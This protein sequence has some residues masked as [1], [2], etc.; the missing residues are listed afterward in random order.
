MRIK[1]AIILTIV[2]FPITV[3][4]SAQP[5]IARGEPRQKREASLA[6]GGEAK[7]PT[8]LPTPA[9]PPATARHKRVGSNGGQVICHADYLEYHRAEGVVIAKGQARIT[10]GNI[11]LE[12]DFCKIDM[13]TED[14]LAEGNC[15]L[16][17]G[18]EEIKGDTLFYNLREDKGKLTNASSFSEP[19]YCKGKEI[20]KVGENLYLT[21]RGSFTTCDLPEPHYKFFAHSARICP[22]KRIWLYN[23]LFCVGKLPIFYL[24]FYTRSLTDKPYGLVIEPSHS[25]K[26]GWKV[27][28]HYSYYFNPGSRG[29]IYLDY[30]ERRGWG[31]GMDYRYAIGDRAQGTL[32][33]YYINE[34]EIDYDPVRDKYFNTG[35]RTERWKVE[36]RHRQELGPDTVG[37]L[38][39]NRLSDQD[40]NKDYNPHEPERVEDR[41]ES[42]LSI[43]RSRPNYTLRFLTKR[44]DKWVEDKDEYIKDTEEIPKLTFTTSPLRVAKAP[45]YYKVGSNLG[46]L[47]NSD[48]DYHAGTWNLYQSL[49]RRFRL[50]PGIN[51]N[52]KVGCKGTWFDKHSN[53]DKSDVWVGAY[54]TEVRLSRRITRC[55][56]GD[57]THS[58]WDNL[59]DTEVTPFARTQER[60]E[61]LGDLRWRIPKKLR[62]KLGCGYDFEDDVFKK[63]IT[64]M[65]AWPRKDV[66]LY[67]E[68]G[69]DIESGKFKN[70]NSNFFFHREM[71]SFGIGNRYTRGDEPIND[72]FDLNANLSFWLT[73][74]WKFTYTSTHRKDN[75]TDHFELRDSQFTVYRDLHCWGAT[76]TLRQKKRPDLEDE[77]SIFLLMNLKVF[78][79]ERLRLHH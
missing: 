14:L 16:W 18:T 11:R 46:Y 19:W 41:P 49:T 1:I 34:K 57:L 65:T 74:K 69:F 9:R 2:I 38:E 42:F 45:I 43:A 36:V 13:A 37:L 22:N 50:T 25:D 30:I 33:G 48:D 62:A 53:L 66:K 79:G 60:N 15:V 20:R 55:L 7:E 58:Y 47:Y 26:E 76:L 21:R 4:I 71:Y 10:H 28:S 5:P 54:D 51:L 78:P 75:I 72:I 23:S 39:V 24:P 3:A 59:D 44:I 29:A 73:P 31:Q 40:F 77:T 63:L 27:K 32:Y 52:S 17:D 67:L 6:F 56:T 70:I 68:T 12:A 8:R 35:Q 64:E 61:L